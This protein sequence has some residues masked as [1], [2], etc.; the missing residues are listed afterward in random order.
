[1]DAV[2]FRCDAYGGLGEVRGIARLDP[3]G[4]V[5]Q[6]QMRDAVLGVLR[7][8][9][10][11]TLIPSPTIVGCDY[12]AGF[13]WLLPWIDL[14][15]SDLGPVENIPSREGG[16]LRLRFAFADRR[17]ARA[18]VTGIQARRAEF[19]LTHFES[20]LER[21]SGARAPAASSTPVAGNATPPTSSLP[22][23]QSE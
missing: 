16:R 5:L 6:Y 21:M 1:M 23:R 11:T 3:N 7:T 20:E 4:L 10:Q 17:A 13:L 18:L 15:V 22:P 8:A 12:R 14:R 2:S 9:T 19:R